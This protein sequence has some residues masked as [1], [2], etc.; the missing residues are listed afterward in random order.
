MECTNP[1][2]LHYGNKKL[3]DRLGL[4]AKAGRVPCGK[5]LACRISRAK[6]WS[7]RLMHESMYHD[8]SL[9]ITLTYDPENEPEEISKKEAQDFIKRLR[10]HLPDQKIKYYITGEYGDKTDRPHYHAIIFNLALSD[11]RVRRTKNGWSVLQGP[12]LKAWKKGFVNAGTVTPDSTRYVAEYIHK[13]LYGPD[14]SS[15]QQPFA[16]MS[17][18]IGSAWMN[19]NKEYLENNAQITFQG[20]PY[21]I[22]KYYREK[23]SLQETVSMHND[24]HRQQKI[25]HYANKYHRLQERDAIN[26]HRKQSDKNIHGNQNMRNKPI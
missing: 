11:H 23:L 8:D 10:K 24:F 3:R 7:I 14:A 16:L 19:N 21:G 13:K 4:H 2:D 5:C 18:G 26:S 9:F 25:S 6:E 22:P 15:R 12:L 20:K 17:Q 1:L